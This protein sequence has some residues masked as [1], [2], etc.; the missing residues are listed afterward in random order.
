MPLMHVW[1]FF[2]G[3]GN[4]FDPIRETPCIVRKVLFWL[5][6]N[7][8]AKKSD[9]P[10][11]FDKVAGCQISFAKRNTI[12]YFFPSIATAR[13]RS[14]THPSWRRCCRWATS[15]PPCTT[16]WG[17]SR[18]WR[19]CSRSVRGPSWSPAQRRR[20]GAAPCLRTGRPVSWRRRRRRPGRRRRRR[21]R[22]RPRRRRR[23]R[24]ID[25]CC[26][27]TMLTIVKENEVSKMCPVSFK[28]AVK[29]RAMPNNSKA[30]C[31][32]WSSLNVRAQELFSPSTAAD[33]RTQNP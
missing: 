11:A 25:K 1:N 31:W 23:L 5:S 2:Q 26:E 27:S 4:T 24:K 16:W 7:K 17:W 8:L 30:G 19:C 15:R 32:P 33:S 6:K 22:R 21:P 20:R 29:V 3:C 9:I 13:T 10:L 28:K 14:M 12:K 18:P